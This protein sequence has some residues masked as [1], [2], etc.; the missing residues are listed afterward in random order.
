MWVLDALISVLGVYFYKDSSVAKF[1]SPTVLP[2]DLNFHFIVDQFY[3]K[4]PVL[5]YVIFE[6]H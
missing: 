1:V 4:N 6:E 5:E 2:G 3:K